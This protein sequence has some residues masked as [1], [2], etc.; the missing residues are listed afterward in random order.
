MS[1]STP[2]VVVRSAEVEGIVI[3]GTV[4]KDLVAS[5]RAQKAIIIVD[6]NDVPE[7]IEVINLGHIR[8][9]SL[10]AAV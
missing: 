2:G 8:D 6:C 1:L 4:S 5:D 3:V 10:P 7:I 9:S